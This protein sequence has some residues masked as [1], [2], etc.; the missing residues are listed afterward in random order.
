MIIETSSTRITFRKCKQ[1]PPRLKP[2]MMLRAQRWS[3]QEPNSRLKPFRR[4]RRFQRKMKRAI[5]ALSV[6]GRIE[7][8]P[9]WIQMLSWACNESWTTTARLARIGTAYGTEFRSPDFPSI[10]RSERQNPALLSGG[11]DRLEGGASQTRME[12]SS[13]RV[14]PFFRPP[15]CCLA[16]SLALHMFYSKLS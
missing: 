12:G 16:L 5:F 8:G 7:F 15:Y 9:N 3:F 11:I 10:Y 6:W 4:F 1:C 14:L 2:Q 13:W